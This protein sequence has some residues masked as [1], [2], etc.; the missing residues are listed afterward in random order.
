M[1]IAQLK[2]QQ[3]SFMLRCN[4][5]LSVA[6][7]SAATNVEFNV[8][9]SNNTLP[10]DPLAAS[11]K[12]KAAEPVDTTKQATEQEQAS[13][14]QPETPKSLPPAQE[15]TKSKAAG[16]TGSKQT[17]PR[18]PPPPKKAPGQ[19]RFAVF[20]GL[21]S[22]LLIAAACLYFW[23]KQT[24]QT[25]RIEQLQKQTADQNQKLNSLQS[26]IQQKL[27][28]LDG[29]IFEQQQGLSKLSQQSYFN[30]QKLADL[31]ARSRM[32]WLLAEAEY[33]MRLANQ[34][35]NLEHDLQS[36]EAMLNSADSILSEIN[37]PGLMQIRQ[38]LAAEITSLQQVQHLDKQGL[39]FRL[40]ALI[41]SVDSLKQQAF[42]KETDRKAHASAQTDT[43]STEAQNNSA[44][45]FVVL[46]HQIWQDLK[47]AVSIRRL[48]QPLPPL[49]APEQHYYLKQNLRLMLEQASLA[50][51][52]E[53]TQVYQ[54]SLKKASSWLNQYFMQNDPQIQQI[55]KTLNN[56]AVYEISQALPDISHSLRLTKAKIESFY[57]QH[58][59][60]KLS[61]PD[62]E[63]D[64]QVSQKPET[65]S[66]PE[67][68]NEGAAL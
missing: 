15:S 9:E 55:Q 20:L 17:P 36:A 11:D 16:P 47:Q 8:T 52:N 2:D 62:T 29:R 48:D 22:L 53:D 57:R 60:N 5:P 31:G 63:T 66:D 34:R 19:S 51:L 1:D 40:E 44:N 7:K 28:S 14:A 61:S 45:R 43:V 24:Q 32:D 25:T 26:G 6:N 39:Y 67:S 58:S 65:A 12:S 38:T 33:L 50:L 30:T 68:K 46:W 18:N 4:G 23:Q 37:D 49:L 54:A 42:L 10:P 27:N 41:N 13:S 59:L 56:M 64:P 3:S 35:L 21:L